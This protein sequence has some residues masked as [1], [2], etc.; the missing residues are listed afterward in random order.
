LVTGSSGDGIPGIMSVMIAMPITLN[1]IT[2]IAAMT[3]AEYS[4]PVRWRK[5]L[6]VPSHVVAIS[7]F[8]ARGLHR[9]GRLCRGCQAREIR[10]KL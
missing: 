8:P 1:M 5:G 4:I 9:I 6:I 2:T 7:C 3:N 10:C